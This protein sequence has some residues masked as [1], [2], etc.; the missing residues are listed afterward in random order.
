MDEKIKNTINLSKKIRKD[1]VYLS[2]LKKTAHLGSSLSCVD[3]ISYIYE[4]IILAIPLKR[5]HPGIED[6]T[7]QSDIV[8]KLRELEPKEE[9]LNGGEDPRWNKLKDLL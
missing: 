2:Y 7:L 1:V 5:I 9:N 3:I 6:G 8:K 4:L